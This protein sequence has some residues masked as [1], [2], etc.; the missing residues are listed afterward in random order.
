MCRLT[1][2]KIIPPLCSFHLSAAQ[3]Y[4][5]NEKFQL[6]FERWQDFSEEERQDSHSSLA[7]DGN[8]CLPSGTLCYRF[9]LLPGKRPE[10][11]TMWGRPTEGASLIS[12]EESL[13]FSLLE[14]TWSVW[15]SH[16]VFLFSL[17]H[18]TEVCILLLQLDVYGENCSS[19][20]VQIAS[21]DDK[22][23]RKKDDV[24]ERNRS[25]LVNGN[26]LKLRRY[27]HGLNSQWQVLTGNKDLLSKEANTAILTCKAINILERT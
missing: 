6:H 2:H 26:S 21:E 4:F 10:L 12:S 25:C 17:Q 23:A 27:H 24:Q 1:V 20:K 3:T 5:W 13:T 8:S 15:R 14:D 11:S 18:N 9:G 16:Q 19:P 7:R 22:M